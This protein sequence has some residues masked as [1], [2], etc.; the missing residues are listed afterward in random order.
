MLVQSRSKACSVCQKRK[1]KVSSGLPGT[2]RRMI[3]RFLSNIHTDILF[4]LTSY[5]PIARN[6]SRM[7]G[8]VQD[9]RPFGRRSPDE[10]MAKDITNVRGTSEYL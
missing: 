7:V 10:S 3:G 2:V 5:P 9:T 6:V 4:S 8:S 1:V